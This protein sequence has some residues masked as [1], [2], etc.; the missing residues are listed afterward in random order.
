MSWSDAVKKLGELLFFNVPAVLAAAK[1]EMS[2]GSVP[3]LWNEKQFNN[4]P[5][6]VKPDTPSSEPLRKKQIPTA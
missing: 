4:G 2:R 6:V 1:D 5:A 3:V